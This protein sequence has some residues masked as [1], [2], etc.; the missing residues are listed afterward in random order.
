VLLRDLGYSAAAASTSV[1]IMA[2]A[3]L[4]GN[5]VIGVFGDN[6]GPRKLL[7][8][9]LLVYACS[10]LLLANAS[11]AWGLYLYAPVMGI[12]FGAAQVGSMALLSLLFGTKPFA[13]LTG[14]GVLIQTGAS[15]I[16]PVIAGAYF[17]S[18]HTYTL[19]IYVLVALNV[20]VGLSLIAARRPL[21]NPV[22]AVG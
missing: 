15:S 12:G 8:G 22:Q 21:R 4:L 3:S 1:A 6:L 10:L 17:D 20:L 2:G 16:V 13:S 5:A 18:H 11:G 19:V 9:A 14:V 7:S